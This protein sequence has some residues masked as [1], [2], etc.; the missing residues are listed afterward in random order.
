M[1]KLS[2]SGKVAFAQL[3]QMIIFSAALFIVLGGTGR[4]FD[5]ITLISEELEPTV[6]ELARLEST[7]ITV[8]D[9]LE[10][11]TRD[12]ARRAD[13]ILVKTRAFQRLHTARNSLK[14]LADAPEL[15]I[16]VTN[17]LK[18]AASILTTPVA[19]GQ[20]NPVD[21]EEEITLARARLTGS[22]D[23][24]T[25]IR[26]N[27]LELKRVLHPV[28]LAIS[29]AA[30]EAASARQEA[31]HDLMGRRSR[32]WTGI[33]AVSTGALALAVLILILAI[34]ATKP[35]GE[36][37]L[38]IRRLA[39]GNLSP[40]HIKASREVEETA[41]AINLLA[42]ALRT[43]RQTEAAEKEREVRTERLAV[44]GRMASAVAHEVRN[45]L[46]SISLNIDLL[47]D[48]LDSPERMGNRSRDIIKAVQREVD[49]LNEITE[50]YLQFGRMP[51]AVIG[52]CNVTGVV[53][54]MCDFMA[55][56][57]EAAG[58][59]VTVTTADDT[60]KVLSDEGQLRQAL[61]N[62]VRNAL[63]A[64]PDGGTIAIGINISTTGDAVILSVKDTGGGIPASHM[65][66]LFEP[67]A[68]T[69]P[70]GTGLGLAFVQQVAHESG[71]SVEIDS[72]EGVGTTVNMR[73]NRVVA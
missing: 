6:E 12:D 21:S 30:K 66:R 45:P 36:I 70:G 1:I 2:L 11:G 31:D 63:E 17:R 51:K 50:D 58:V 73:L 67:F 34:H 68:T 35:I 65:T 7:I 22:M 13:K 4:L 47:A 64:Q 71:G 28:R 16:G 9:F 59:A 15:G 41:E 55:G 52:P 14:S 46:N 8:E 10:S 42:Q 32:L 56:E 33:L 19:A 43:R 3:A 72:K 25:T 29:R 5:E 39:S 38:A 48:M 57:F 60:L 49:R 27:A 61:V 20:K 44:V 40:I 24:A 37:T 62:I 69:K 18:K 23:D 53:R 26:N 54:E